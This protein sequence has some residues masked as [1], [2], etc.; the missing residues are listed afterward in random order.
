MLTNK[1]STW[2]QV[3]REIAGITRVP[4]TR[5]RR[6]DC[7]KH[8]THHGSDNDG[9]STS[10]NVKVSKSA[11]VGTSSARVDTA[12]V[13]GSFTKPR[14][15][16]KRASTANPIV[17]ASARLRGRKGG[18]TKTSR[19]DRVLPAEEVG[20]RSQ[21][22]GDGE[23]SSAGGER[24][25]GPLRSTPGAMKH[26]KS[27]SSC[28]DSPP[29]SA[30]ASAETLGE[31]QVFGHPSDTA[32][33]SLLESMDDRCSCEDSFDVYDGETDSLG[34]SEWDCNSTSSRSNSI[35]DVEALAQCPV[36]DEEPPGQ[37][38]AGTEKSDGREM[39][40]EQEQ[41][42]QE[43]EEGGN[44]A[45]VRQKPGKENDSSKATKRSRR[46]RRGEGRR[47]QGRHPEGG[48]THLDGAWSNRW[49]TGRK[50]SECACRRAMLRTEK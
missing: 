50:S 30:P 32:V 35:S 46:K 14:P 12:G 4:S 33:A 48:S 26:Q 16:S 11:V 7:C 29:A 40:E 28:R 18:S 42:E 1:S 43:E 21:P 8:S 47:K 49:L 3:T 22:R 41:E 45:L 19:S 36:R 24:H 31:V 17:A 9:Q 15:P 25:P 44:N 2:E 27:D 20:C 6:R 38:K 39:E 23:S 34:T 5:V 37:S 13:H 10:R